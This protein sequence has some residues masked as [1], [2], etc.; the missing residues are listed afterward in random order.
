MGLLS[1]SVKVYL[2]RLWLYIALLLFSG[3][4]VGLTAERLKYTLHL[5]PTDPL[6]NGKPFFDR[7]V[8]E[9]FA[10]SIF[11]FFWSIHMIHTISRSIEKG[12]FFRR[13]AFELIFMWILWVLYLVGA[14]VATTLWGD[15]SFCWQ[16]EACR[17][18]TA[19]VAFSW[20][21]WITITVLWVTTFIFA[22]T[23]GAWMRP[24]HTRWAFQSKDAY[25]GQV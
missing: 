6:N 25:P 5:P 10:T 23:R 19:L 17:L 21:G 24:A 11:T 1:F 16:F 14:A 8:A 15:L 20:I 18:L 13:I 7:V 3:T 9:L 2:C 22:F 4:L 12:G